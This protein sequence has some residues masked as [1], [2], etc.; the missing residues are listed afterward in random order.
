[1]LLL[2]N[3]NSIHRVQAHRVAFGVLNQF[4]FTW[5]QAGQT[6][7]DYRQSANSYRTSVN[8]EPRHALL[9]IIGPNYL[10]DFL[11]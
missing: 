2:A 8:P 6:P 4:P 11:Y 9:D 3:G 7:N 10:C 1:M 5:F